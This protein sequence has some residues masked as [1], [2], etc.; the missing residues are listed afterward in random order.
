MLLAAGQNVH[1]RR[2]DAERPGDERVVEF[3]DL[4]R[5]WIG[6]VRALF[7]LR[8]QVSG[9]L[10]DGGSVVEPLDVLARADYR[11]GIEDG[12]R[13]GL[14]IP[15]IAKL[16]GRPPQTVTNEIKSRRIER[17]HEELRRI[18]IKG[19][20]FDLIDQDDVCLVL[21]HVNSYSR[22]SRGN[23][24]PYDEFV[25]E[26]GYEGRRFLERLG[27]VKIPAN[28]VTLDPYLLGRRDELQRVQASIHSHF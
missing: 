18:L 20:N 26:Y 13:L 22:A 6:R 23:S 27:V 4:D 16:I 7:A 8:G 9:E 25:K 14:S 19:T 11:H 12:L 2:I 17:V 1:R 28:E 24:T 10:A 5:V 15:E 3:L 21:S